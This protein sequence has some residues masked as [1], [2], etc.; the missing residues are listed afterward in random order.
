MQGLFDN[1]GTYIQTSPW[2][3]LVVVFL[4][5]LLTAS[6]PCVLAMIPLTIGF[7]SGDNA[8]KSTKRAFIFS[9]LFVLG[10]AVMFTGMGIAAALL[11]KLFGRVSSVWNLVVAG[12]CLLMG[13]HLTGLLK[14]PIPQL[15]VNPKLKG[16]AGAFVL[17]LLFGVVSA[18]C[19]AP[20]LVVLL[21]YIAGSGS[22]VVYGG[23]LLLAY[24]SGHCALIV[25]AGTSMGAAKAVI[26]NKRLTSATNL[27]RR[28]AGVLIIVVGGFFAFRGLR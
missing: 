20:M 28:A 11:G 10:L 9:L 26:E 3:A 25:V 22:S 13:L 16:T 18:P 15:N 5:G 19:A 17:G 2:L 6:N 14:I 12:V 8:I 24:A 23:L 27:L 7:V 1:V 4:G 21:A